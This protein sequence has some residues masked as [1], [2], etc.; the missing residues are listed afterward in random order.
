MVNAVILVTKRA[1]KTRLLLAIE[2]LLGVIVRNQVTRG[3]VT[4]LVCWDKVIV[5]VL[6]LNKIWL[7]NLLFLLRLSL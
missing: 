2:N 7:V 5:I 1:E 6:L 3:S 4:V